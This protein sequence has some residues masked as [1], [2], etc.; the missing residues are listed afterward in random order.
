MLCCVAAFSPVSVKDSH[1]SRSDSHSAEEQSSVA[2]FNAFNAPQCIDS[3]EMVNGAESQI[4]TILKCMK[5][6][7]DPM[8]IPSSYKRNSMDTTIV[9]SEVRLNNLIEVR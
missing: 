1:L 2:D 8:M 5:N 7:S 9:Y 3:I 4:L 6:I